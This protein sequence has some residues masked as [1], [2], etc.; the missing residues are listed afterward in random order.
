MQ[1]P[2]IGS[3]SDT[4]DK[5]F[6]KRSL[7]SI[8]EFLPQAEI[9]LSTWKGADSSGLEFDKIVFNDD[10]GACEYFGGGGG[11]NNVNR[12]IVST[13]DGMRAATRDFVLKLRSDSVLTGSGFLDYFGRFPQRSH[14]SVFKE[15][16]VTSSRG[17]FIPNYRMLLSCYFPSDWFHFGCREDLLDLWDIPLAPE[18][19]TTLWLPPGQTPWRDQNPRLRFAIEQYIWVSFLR[20]NFTFVFDSM[21]DQSESSI[22]DSELGIG[23]NLILIS[24][25]Q[26]SIRSL[27]Y[28]EAWGF[29]DHCRQGCYT[30][31][32]WRSLYQE[33]CRGRR[34][35]VYRFIRLL[36]W[37]L[38]KG[39]D[40]RKFLRGLMRRDG[41]SV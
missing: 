30:H 2:V 35:S 13:F 22:A 39:G 19:E 8:R 32:I 10:P 38:F 23:S 26:A 18:P 11:R 31:G 36:Y 34:L 4:P 12:Q 21:W 1:G 33:H 7:L 5:R 28:P 29:L 27:K 3:P 6:T 16:V 14:R 41:L 20:K 15:K 24:P 17:S 25:E 37:L 40:C 9:I